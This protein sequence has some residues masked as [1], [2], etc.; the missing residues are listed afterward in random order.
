ME[1]EISQKILNILKKAGEPLETGEIEEQMKGTTRSKIMYRLSD[2]RAENKIKGKR[3]S[4]GGKG[5]W[6]WWK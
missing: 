2:L 6:I 5:V 1:D 4:S 3:I